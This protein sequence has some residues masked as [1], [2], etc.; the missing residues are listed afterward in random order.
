M[1]EKIKSH[2]I[3]GVRERVL[4]CFGFEQLVLPL[5]DI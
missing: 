1:E 3:L 4:F 2:S 5:N